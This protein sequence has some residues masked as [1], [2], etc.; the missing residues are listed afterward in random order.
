MLIPKSNILFRLQAGFVEGVIEEGLKFNSLT[1]AYQSI[2]RNN[3]EFCLI[4]WNSIPFALSYPQDI[5]YII[6][7]ICDTL[8]YVLF[9]TNE[10]VVISFLSPQ[11]S[12]NWQLTKSESKTII[13]ARFIKVIG[14]H[15]EALNAVSNLE[16][17]SSLFLAEWKLL[18]EQLLVSFDASRAKVVTKHDIDLVQRLRRINKHIPNRALRYQYSIRRTKKNNL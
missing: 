6:R 13:R 10:I 7:S 5:S 14:G 3:K 4:C 15:E 2:F 18:I 12:F 9:S 1:E 17:K 8:E 16:I 11:T